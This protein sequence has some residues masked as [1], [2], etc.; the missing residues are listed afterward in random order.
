M[1][2]DYYRIK[3]RRILALSLYCICFILLSACGSTTDS[4]TTAESAGS[5][6]LATQ[7]E[8][9]T[10]QET[11]AAEDS[12]GTRDNT[13]QCLVP[14]APGTVTYGNEVVSIDA[15]NINNG[16]LC[17]SYLGTNSKVK[18]QITGP[19]QVTY[20][21]D[22]YG[23][24]YETFPLTC[25]DGTY[26]VGVYENI[27]GTQYATTFYQELNVTLADP[28]LPFLYPNQYVNFT[29]ESEVVLKAE[30][31]AAPAN[32]DLDV[33]S[34][35]YNYVVGSISYD[36]V[37][38][39]DLPNGYLSDVDETLRS[40]SGICLDYAALMAA[41]LRSQGIPTHLEVGYAKEAHHAWISTYVDEKGWINGMIEFDGTSWSI[42]D[43]TYAANSSE[44]SLKKFIGDG[45]NYTVKYVY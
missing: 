26:S 32:T 7:P 19:D 40:G 41:M 16:Y 43:P 5:D 15:S 34:N 30:E 21:Y 36:D 29:P 2:K 9:T 24:D 25:E 44:K 22:L 4:G 13:P 45:S 39:A 33:V 20:T 14:E 3:T 27:S 37:K 6:V 38:A 31:L 42:L 10:P 35:I 1:K 17:V 8:E 11:A 12:K 23:K 18:L 28:F